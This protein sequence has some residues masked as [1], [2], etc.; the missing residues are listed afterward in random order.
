M[1]SIISSY[2]DNFEVTLTTPVAR[3]LDQEA[4]VELGPQPG[5]GESQLLPFSAH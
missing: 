2:E 5:S 1:M 4:H 3:L